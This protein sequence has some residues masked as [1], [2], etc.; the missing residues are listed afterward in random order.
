MKLTPHTTHIAQTDKVHEVEDLKDTLIQIIEQNP[1]AQLKEEHPVV[2]DSQGWPKTQIVFSYTLPNR[3]PSSYQIYSFWNPNFKTFS[4]NVTELSPNYNPRSK[5]SDDRF[6][7]FTDSSA[8]DLTS[9]TTDEVIAK[10]RTFLKGRL[11]RSH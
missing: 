4:V 2:Q 5:K 9:P 11:K 6:N 10:F 7:I 3:K 8:W 1:R